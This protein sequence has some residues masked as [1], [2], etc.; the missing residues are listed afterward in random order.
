MTEDKG[1]SYH[2]IPSLNE[3]M[4]FVDR[5]TVSNTLLVKVCNLSPSSP[6]TKDSLP[7]VYSIQGDSGTKDKPP[8]KVC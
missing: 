6:D 8:L 1:R 5:L 2:S 7:S 3:K 4:V